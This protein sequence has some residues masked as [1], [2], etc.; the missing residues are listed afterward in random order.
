[1]LHVASWERPESGLGYILKFHV[2][3]WELPEKLLDALG[4]VMRS[5]IDSGC[6]LKTIIS[7]F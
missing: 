6:A 5:K 2:A 3:S 7:H 4:H 1:M